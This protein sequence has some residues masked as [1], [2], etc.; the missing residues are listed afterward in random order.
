[1]LGL[2]GCLTA[3]ATDLNTVYS[4]HL[5]PADPDNC[6]PKPLSTPHDVTYSV[7]PIRACVPSTV[8]PAWTLRPPPQV[9]GRSPRRVYL[10]PRLAT[11]HVLGGVFGRMT[12][13]RQ[14][15]KGWE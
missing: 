4:H 9:R 7:F 2:A 11:V 8:R 14:F 12:G 1:M 10:K 13:A 15:A 3:R 5:R 6:P